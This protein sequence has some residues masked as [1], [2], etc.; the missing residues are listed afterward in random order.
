MEIILDTSNDKN[1]K[2]VAVLK[3]KVCNSTG[4]VALFLN[5]DFD[6]HDQTLKLTV[7]AVVSHKY[8]NL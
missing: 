1:V 3:A 2:C 6:L 7:L 8:I 4:V 5:V